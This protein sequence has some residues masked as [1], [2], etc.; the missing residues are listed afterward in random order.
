[1]MQIFTVEKF[2][3]CLKLEVC[4]YVQGVVGFTFMTLGHVFV[5]GLCIFGIFNFD[6]AP[7]ILEEYGIK[8]EGFIQIILD[9]LLSS[10]A[11]EKIFIELV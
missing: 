2:L 5:I 9:F 1:M 3:C 11:G 4:A 10:R 7:E 6:S 8:F